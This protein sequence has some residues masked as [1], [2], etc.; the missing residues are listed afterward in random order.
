MFARRNQRTLSF[1]PKASWGLILPCNHDKK[2]SAEE[3]AFRDK[4]AKKGGKYKYTS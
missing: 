4:M 3:K 1:R 2:A